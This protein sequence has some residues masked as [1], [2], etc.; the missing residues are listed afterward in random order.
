M[1]KEQCANGVQKALNSVGIKTTTINNFNHSTSSGA[2]FPMSPHDSVEVN[3][4][5]PGSAF[6]AI[7]DD[8]KP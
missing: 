1:V 2:V 5:L 8:N 7:R 3:P 6:K 4:Y